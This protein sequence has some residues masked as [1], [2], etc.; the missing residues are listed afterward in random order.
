MK[1]TREDLIKICE[2]A[3]VSEDK[4]NNRDSEQAQSKL[5]Q[6]YALLKDGCDFEVIYDDE[7]CGT[8]EYTIW[9]YVYSKGFSYFEN[10]DFNDTEEQRK[11]YKE[12]YHFYLPTY[13]RL[14]EV[15]G[16]D[17]Y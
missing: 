2:K 5:G 12:K 7:M 6:C 14:A 16:G 10:C 13:T 4:W 1:Y 17:W 3:F 15:N 9:L 8:D 11:S